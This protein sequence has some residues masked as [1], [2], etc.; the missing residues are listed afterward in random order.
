MDF[1]G[2]NLADILVASGY[3]GFF[4]IIFAE[5]GIL[6][7]FFLPGDSLI[8]TAGLLAS[9]DIFNLWILIIGGSISAILGDSFGY[10][11]GRRFGPSVFSKDSGLIRN[12]NHL[13]K[14]KQYYKRYGPITIVIARFVPIIRT[15]APTLAG[16][17]EMR[18][19]TFLA[20]NIIG[21]V[22]WIISMSLLGYFI[23]ELVP[24]IDH[25]ILPIIAVIVLVSFMP[26]LTAVI[27]N[28]RKS[29]VNPSEKNRR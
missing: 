6:A 22:L 1:L 14:A 20:Y 23:G 25:F 21:G 7:G 12:R 2:I 5:S 17:G 16:V 28:R 13:E 26:V 4:L 19:R 27:H 10:Y 29:T 11:L 18:Y 24:N 3:I 9:K 8:F 15:F